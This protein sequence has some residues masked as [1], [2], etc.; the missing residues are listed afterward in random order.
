M[1]SLKVRRDY[2][3]CLLMDGQCLRM[4]IASRVDN[5]YGSLLIKMILVFLTR[6]SRVRL[7]LW[8]FWVCCF[9]PPL[10]RCMVSRGERVVVVSPM[11]MFGYGVH[12]LVNGKN[13]GK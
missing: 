7:I 3:I 9:R 10:L 6:D 12:S 2:V 5:R 11:C 4:Y 1:K 13:V 8:E